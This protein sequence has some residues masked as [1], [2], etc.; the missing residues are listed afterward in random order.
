MQENQEIEQ[1]LSSDCSSAYFNGFSLAIGVGDVLIALQHNGNPHIVLNTS[2]TV[3]KTLA[4][5]LTEAIEQLEEKTGNIIMT[6]DQIQN[7][8]DDGDSDEQ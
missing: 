2:Y 7:S 8:L 5:A 4:K 1:L 6:V 3:A